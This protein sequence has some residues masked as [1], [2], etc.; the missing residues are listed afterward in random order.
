MEAKKNNA[1]FKL[2]L[3]SGSI[4][5]STVLYSAVLYFFY[6]INS[7]ALFESTDPLLIK[8]RYG[9]LLASILIA[10]FLG[11][12]YRYVFENG[13]LKS[14][15]E[16]RTRYDEY[17]DLVDW[18]S[19]PVE[20]RVI[21]YYTKTTIVLMSIA[22]IPGTLG[23]VLGILGQTFNVSALHLKYVIGL[24]VLS[25]VYKIALLPKE[26][27]LDFLKMRMETIT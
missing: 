25:L 27:V 18:S 19:K 10:F 17:R 3:I 23:L 24:L 21:R 14:K 1:Y 4:L 15:I 26:R 9:C 20:G 12:I 7:I 6:S 2:Q 8:A 5:M 13:D 22:D 16:K 11:L